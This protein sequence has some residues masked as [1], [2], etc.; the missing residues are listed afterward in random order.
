MKRSVSLGSLLVVVLLAAPLVHWSA[1]NATALAVGGFCGVANALLVM[2][3]N[4]RV[5]ERRRVGAFVLSSILRV[6]LFGIV[7]VVLAAHGSWWTFGCYFAGFFTPLALYGIVLGRA[8][9]YG[10]ND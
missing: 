7:P 2:A 1:L 4:E 3:G 5:I 8:Y 9:K 10:R 6:G